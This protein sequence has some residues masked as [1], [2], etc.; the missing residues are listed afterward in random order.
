MHKWACRPRLESSLATRYMRVRMTTDLEILMRHNNTRWRAFFIAVL[1]SSLWLLHEPASAAA[2]VIKSPNDPRQYESFVLPNQLT[3]L[4]ISDPTTDKAAAALDVYVGSSSNPEGWEGLAHFLEHML[5]LGTKKYPEAGEYQAFISKHG[6]R[7]NAYT[8]DDNTNYF[9]DIDKNYLEPALDRFAQ[10]F[11]APSFTPQYVDRERNAVD[12]EYQTRRKDD[13]SRLFH[14]WK[15]AANPRHPFSR[16]QIGSLSTLVDHHDR[17]LREALIEFYRRHYSANIM[18][19]VVLGKEP[20]PVLKQWVTEKF[21]AIRNV[22]ARPFHTSE[23]LLTPGTLPARLNVVPLEDRRVLVMTF[24]IPPV[25]HYWRRK[26]VHY[27]ANLL[28]YEGKGSLLSLLKKQ[29]WAE[30]LSAGLGISNV[31]EAT[32]SVSME[33]TEEGLQHINEI[34][35][36]LFRYIDLIREQGITERIFDEQRR[37][38]EIDFRF[39]ER[40]SAIRYASMLA[41]NLQIYP[42]S[43]VLRGPYEMDRYDPALI[44]LFL[45]ELRPD[46]LLL[47]VNAKGLPTNAEE[48][49]FGTP[50][51]ITQI[52]PAL[53]AQWRRPAADIRL[54]IPAPNIFLPDDLTVKAPKD[55]TAKPVRI[56]K[57]PGLELWFKQDTTFRVPRA[58][59]YFSLRSP[60]ANDSPK[61]AALTELYVKLVNDQLNEFAYPAHLAGLSYEL[62][63]HLRG[64]S[65][66]ISGYSDKQAVLL[67]RVVDALAKPVVDPRRFAIA[68]DELARDLKN[69]ERETPY[70]QTT[71]E[72]TKLLLRPYWPEEERHAALGS[73]TADDLVEFVPKLLSRIYIVVLA[74]GNLYRTDALESTDILQQRLLASATPT[75]VPA[76]EV[77]RLPSGEEFVR[78]LHIDHPDSALTVYVQ[79]PS[80]RYSTLAKTA[81][82]TQLVSTPFYNDLRTEKQLGYVVFASSLPVLEVPGIAFVVQSPNTGPAALKKN[83]D[84]FI[85]GYADLLYA[86]SDDDF[87]RHK[88]ALLTRIMQK[89]R[90]L[91]ARSDRYWT[92]IDRKRY[93]FDSRERL[94]QAV[95]RIDKKTLER[96]YRDLLLG[97]QHR[98]LVVLSAGTNHGGASVAGFDSTETVLIGDISAFKQQHRYFPR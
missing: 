35:S 42:A 74:H 71:S 64:I 67:S 51:R 52:S 30:T 23:P 49:W 43:E 47:T 26:P 44:R 63:K 90:N 66:R 28:G 32:L 80:K 62:Y 94:A 10:F 93:K 38:A 68:K 85:S 21:S 87:A 55:V 73:L 1:I 61:H 11:I 69:I 50:Y 4:I 70:R 77:V 45:D 96:Y 31:S 7:H 25:I 91:Q 79:G 76:G 78:M 8:S 16:F 22:N 14:A 24:P 19:L 15:T 18:T 36:Y 13:S 59:F 88:Q 97:K 2:E 27:I 84:D 5:F 6:G 48:L 3:A 82:V 92:D 37:I 41:A 12:S 34:I 39:K 40:T 72:V 20:L 83:V 17:K 54:A 65:V 33:L 46:N 86:M 81:L 95:R 75:A 29:G 98:H 89:D 53:V 57:A 9:F 60:L 56:K 58:D